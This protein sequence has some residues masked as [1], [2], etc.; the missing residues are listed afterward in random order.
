MTVRLEL[1]R[2]AQT[3]AGSPPVEALQPTTLTIEPG[4]YVGIVG[5]SGSGKSTL[6]NLLGLLDVPSAGSYRIDGVDVQALDEPDRC[7]LRAT[8]LGFVFQAYHLAPDRSALE[9]VELGLLY[10]RVDP[11]LRRR[12][13][14]DALEQVGLSARAGALPTT[15]SGGEQ[16]RVAIARAIVGDRRVLLCDEPTGNLDSR[17]SAQVLDLIES[18]HDLGL[19]VVMV[20]HDADV[21]RR[22]RRL[23][24][25]ADGVVTQIR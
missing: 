4:D 16:Q 25:V 20:T 11:A 14:L 3:Y 9:N 15:L 24:R 12:R 2:A 7:G 6:L 1:E 13:A 8:V 10:R 21:A 5:P 19:T 22:P 18:L 23:L 17:T